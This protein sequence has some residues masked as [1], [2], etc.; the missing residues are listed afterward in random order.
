MNTD[1]K[2]IQNMFSKSVFICVN[3]WLPIFF[4]KIQAP[5]L[6]ED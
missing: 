4:L 1:K 5:A 2:Q 3:L 6:R